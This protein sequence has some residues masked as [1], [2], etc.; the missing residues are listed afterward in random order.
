M[1]Q[2]QDIKEATDHVRHQFRHQGKLVEAIQYDGTPQNAEILCD[3]AGRSVDVKGYDGHFGNAV[4]V[5]LVTPFGSRLLFPTD[6]VVS[7]G[8]GGYVAI[9]DSLFARQH[10]QIGES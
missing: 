7:N 4:S 9:N 3:F 10:E 5:R 1:G 6:W 8:R 2:H